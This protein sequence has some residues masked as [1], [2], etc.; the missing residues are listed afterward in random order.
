M[1]LQKRFFVAAMATGVMLAGFFLQGHRGPLGWVTEGGAHAPVWP[2][3]TDTADRVR[4]VGLELLPM[5]GSVLHFHV[6]LDV[7]YRGQPVT[8]P[9]NVGVV[10]GMGFSALHSHADAGLIH[11]ESPTRREFRLGQFFTEWGVPLGGASAWVNG[12][13]ISDPAGLVLHDH[14]QIVVTY[15][16]PPA[17]IPTSF[18]SLPAEMM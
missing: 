16:T 15:G 7:F 18:P 17:R 2:R 11:V 4:A 8:V 13:R 5:E 14:Q 9:A 3:P 10:P 1:V 6:H 12:H